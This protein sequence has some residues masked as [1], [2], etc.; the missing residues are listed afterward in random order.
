VITS[1]RPV[2]ARLAAG[3]FLAL[4]VVPV[5][6]QE[7]CLACHGAD[8]NSVTRAFLPLPDSRPRSWKR[9]WC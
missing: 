6:S 8:G 7:T 2:V 5:A 1:G 9:S 3:L 4:A